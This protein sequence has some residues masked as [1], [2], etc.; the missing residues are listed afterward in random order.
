[1]T[2]KINKSWERTRSEVHS[3]DGIVELKANIKSGL[4][5]KYSGL[6][7]NM[8]SYDFGS[9]EF[10]DMRIMSRDTVPEKFLFKNGRCCWFQ[11]E[12][13]KQIHCLPFV[14]NAAGINIYGQINEW[15]PVPVGY[16]D[17]KRGTYSAE[18][19]RIRNT[20]LNADTSVIMKNDIFGMGDMAFVE[21]MVNELVDNVLT[22]N[23]LQL[24]AA[25]PFVFNVTEDNL[26]TAKNFFLAVAEHKP[27]I[28]T[29]ANGEKVLPIVE[30]I[31][32][33]IDPALFELFDRFECQILE[34]AGFPCV[35]ITKRAQ[36]SVSEVE[37]NSE[38]IRARRED[39]FNQR[40]IACERISRMWGV[41]ITVHSL[42]D[43][44]IDEQAK[45]EMEMEVSED[46]S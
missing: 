7:E 22:M 18:V 20:V 9:E 41:N 5:K 17:D 8:F 14:E 25:Y 12:R 33:K 4:I 31:E 24:L 28:F 11:D 2:S 26:L 30:K 39:R 44:W 1:M 27:V 32:A 19:E 46:E 34:M 42:I 45:D 40:R 3:P 6:F 35:P 43:E 38:K 10:E 23:Q 36:Q 37:S 21:S 13:T 29:N 16:T 15:S